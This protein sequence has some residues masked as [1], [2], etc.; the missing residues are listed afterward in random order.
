M[1]ATLENHHRSSAIISAH[2]H[3]SAL[4]HRPRDPRVCV[5]RA[6][7]NLARQ[8]H[9][10]ERSERPHQVE[11]MTF[12]RGGIPPSVVAGAEGLCD[13]CGG[14]WGTG[15]G[16]GGARAGGGG[17]RGGRGRERGEGVGRGGGAGG[18]MR[19][20]RKGAGGQRARLTHPASASLSHSRT[21]DSDVGGA[22]IPGLLRRRRTRS[23]TTASEG[24][25]E[26]APANPGSP[27]T[28]R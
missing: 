18:G 4:S 9:W 1:G 26:E 25:E 12:A 2:A 15:G 8:P 28:L 27:R 14:R 16:E 11:T 23:A 19:T 20:M 22:P 7:A 24:K 5:T 21:Q 17:E 6:N 13:S 3:T 10:R